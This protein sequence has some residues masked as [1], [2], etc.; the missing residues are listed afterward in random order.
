MHSP[1]VFD[2][3]LQV[4]N[5]KSGYQPPLQLEILRKQLR[6]DETLLTVE[7]LGAGSRVQ[8]AKQK[9]IRHIARTAVKPKKYSQLLF[10]MVKHYQPQTILELG[11]SLGLSTAYMAAANPDATI[12]TIEG[13]TEIQQQ[14]QKNFNTLDMGF[15]KSLQGAFDDVLP[16]VLQTIPILTWRI[17]MATTACN[18]HFLI[19]SCCSKN[20]LTCP[21]SFLMTSI[22]VRRWKKPGAPS[23]NTR[24]CAI[25]S[26]CFF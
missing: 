10:R 20:E 17:L 8:A 5:N 23:K 1:F 3:I 24:M 6:Q 15:I 16:H 7:D 12:I 9:T 26:T 4:L 11:T 22:G 2:F 25:P 19:L 18:P 13:S 21:F 14:A